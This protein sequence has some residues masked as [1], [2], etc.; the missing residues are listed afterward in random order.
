MYHCRLNF[1]LAGCECKEFELIRDTAPPER[2]TYNF[3]EGLATD[4][5]A[6]VVFVN[7]RG[8]SAGELSQL[9]EEINPALTELI[10]LA[11]K[12]LVPSV[13][14]KLQKISDIWILPMSDT[15]FKFRLKKWK[16]RCKTDKDFLETSQYLEATINSVPNLVGY[17]DKEGIH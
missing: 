10:L 9:I 2:F 12:E 15:E 3:S 6:D 14:D 1:Y 7:T 5:K 13:E 4:I 16:E 17:K 11:P 8:M